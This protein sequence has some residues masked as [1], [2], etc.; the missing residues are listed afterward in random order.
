MDSQQPQQSPHP[1]NPMPYGVY[2][3]VAFML[4]TSAAGLIVNLFHTMSMG[5]PVEARLALAVSPLIVGAA[6][7]A[8]VFTF[9]R[10]EKLTLKQA[11]R[12]GIF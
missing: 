3:I 9:G 4:G 6:Y 5:W 12:R 8:R 1:D 11:L 7:G 2:F 10:A